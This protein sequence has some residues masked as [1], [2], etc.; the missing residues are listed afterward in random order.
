VFGPEHRGQHAAAEEVLFDQRGKVRVESAKFGEAPAEYDHIRV[1]QV[2]GGGEGAADAVFEAGEAGL[3]GWVSG[4][5]GGYDL[6]AGERLAGDAAVVV[7]EPGA[8]DPGFE[9]AVLSAVAGWA[10]GL[11]GGGPGQGVVAPLSR[12]AVWADADV[13]VDGDASAA[14][15]AQDDGEDQFSPCGGAVGGLGDGEAVGVVG[16]PDGSAECGEQVALKRL[17]VEPGG[18]GVLDQASGRDNG[19]RDAQADGAG[20]A[21][22]LF[23]IVDDLNDGCDGGGVVVLRGGNAE[24][25]QLQAGGIEGQAFDLGAAEV[26]SD[27]DE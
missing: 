7:A 24:P 1:E 14:A 15:G 19:S 16:A 25:G 26:D 18:V 13:P 2:D 4:F 10:G 8:G 20:G 12:D 11:G 5:G 21:G 23:E 9:A 27:P 17:A 6:G 22:A 3:S